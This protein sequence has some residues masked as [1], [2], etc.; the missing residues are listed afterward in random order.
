M[1][2]HVFSTGGYFSEYALAAA[3]SSLAGRLQP[4]KL[5]KLCNE[6]SLDYDPLWFWCALCSFTDADLN[7]TLAATVGE[8][9]KN[10]E[11]ILLNPK[12][13][14]NKKKWKRKKRKRF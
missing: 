5:R 12:K 4:G 3:A 13:P 8:A 6:E 14:S 7:V 10:A 1:H 11:A 2:P 9:N